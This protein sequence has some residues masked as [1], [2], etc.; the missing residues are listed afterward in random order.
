MYMH[1]YVIVFKIVHDHNKEIFNTD[2]YFDVII[3]SV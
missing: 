1:A 2:I 3:F